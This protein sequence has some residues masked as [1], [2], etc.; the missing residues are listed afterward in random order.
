MRCAEDAATLSA[1]ANTAISGRRPIHTQT[2]ASPAK[3]KVTEAASDRLEASF[4]RPAAKAAALMLDAI[5][6]DHTEFLDGLPLHM[7]NA[8]ATDGKAQPEAG[9]FMLSAVKDME[10][11]D[12]V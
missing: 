9:S 2:T 8:T 11:R 10:P 12:Q 3:T 7:I 4:H 1:A 6:S 5:V